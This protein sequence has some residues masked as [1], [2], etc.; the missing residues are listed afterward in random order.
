MLF[1]MSAKFIF[2]R[3]YVYI[4]NKLG[5]FDFTDDDA[6]ELRKYLDP[7][8]EKF[9][10]DTEKYYMSFYGLLHENLLPYKSEAD[11]TVTNILLPKIATH[12]LIYYAKS[13][14]GTDDSKND[15]SNS[16]YSVISE[17]EIKSVQ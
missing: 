3:I 14:G 6:L 16:D 17:R 13:G 4:R 9:H 10:G 5:S 1:N 15:C 2:T 11:I 8:I 7:I 12:L